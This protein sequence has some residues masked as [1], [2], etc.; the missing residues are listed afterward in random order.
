MN[1]RPRVVGSAALAM[2]LLATGCGDSIRDAF[3]VQRLHKFRLEPVTH[4]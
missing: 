1:V 2:S 3:D 4:L